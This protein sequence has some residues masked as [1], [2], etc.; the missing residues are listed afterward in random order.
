MRAMMRGWQKY[1][2]AKGAQDDV[3][4]NASR[5][6]VKAIEHTWGDHVKLDAWQTPSSWSNEQFEKDRHSAAG[7]NCTNQA[8][9]PGFA[10]LEASW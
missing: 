7:T 1:T 4:H 2:D 9:C 8:N 5:F 3:Y 10:F 6:F